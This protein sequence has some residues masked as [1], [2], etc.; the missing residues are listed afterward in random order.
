MK[1]FSIGLGFTALAAGLV[2]LFFGTNIVFGVF[3]VTTGVV[4]MVYVL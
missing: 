3:T 2:V 1:K 4:L